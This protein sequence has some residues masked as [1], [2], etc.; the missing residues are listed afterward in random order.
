MR[1]EVNKIIEE[2]RAQGVIEE[3]QSPWMSPAVL[4]RKKDGSLRFCVDYRKLN[5]VT[6]KDSYPLPKI[7][8]ILDQL[9][10]NIWFSTLDLKSGY[11][12][13]KIRSE[14][15]EKIAFSIGNG[16]WQFTVMPFGLCNAPATFER[17]IEKILHGLLYKFC[18]VYLDDVIIYGKSF[19][20]M[21]E[22]LGKVFTR[23][24]EVN[25]KVNPKE[26]VVALIW[27]KGHRDLEGQ[28]ARWL[29]ELQQYEFEV[30]HRKGLIHKNADEFSRRLCE[31][32]GY[33]YCSRVEEKN[34]REKEITIAQISLSEG[35]LEN[36]R[37]EQ[38]EDPTISIFCSTKEAG[39]RP[40]RSELVDGNVFAL[41][42]W[43]YWDALSLKN[44]ILYR[45]WTAPDL[46]SNILQLI[47]PRKMLR[48]GVRSVKSAFPEGGPSG[49]GKSLLQVYNVRAPFV[50]VQMDIIGPFPSSRNGNKY[51]LVII[52]CFTT[53][54]EAFPLKNIKAKIV[55]EIFVSQVIS[56]H[57]VPLEVHTDQGRNFE[58]KLFTELMFLLGS[59]KTRTTALHPQSNENQ[60]DWDRWIPMFLLA[61]RSAKHETTGISP[62]EMYF[63][64]DLK[65]PLDLFRGSPPEFNEDSQFPEDYVGD[66]R[67]KLRELHAVV[68]KQ[69]DIKSF[70]VK[71][72]EKRKGKVWKV[73]NL[74]S[75]EGLILAKCSV[76]GNSTR[77][78]E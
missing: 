75:Q 22:N 24:R 3:S 5:E 10:G 42:Y 18:L 70:R 49:K 30:H 50:R 71:A 21:L 36:W 1:G 68:R 35:L 69:M 43:S 41:I 39:M 32:N 61:Y 46:R 28:L 45:R 56:R 73:L 63:A 17:V 76:A 12:Q 54:V 59:K 65:L 9:S 33:G 62:A 27:I 57:G 48:N 40:V 14:D 55:A 4:V 58:S 13:V 72:W 74:E 66:L 51:L 8:D 19:S 60:K 53:W 15:K 64:R 34:A 31:T 47:L 29:K 44:G 16:L 78:R 77:R 7:D 37:K 11:W 23:L 6:V 2:M 67:L 20:E 52:D 26:C 38:R 25:L